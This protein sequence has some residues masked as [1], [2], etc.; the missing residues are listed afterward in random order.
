MLFG[1]GDP[2]LQTGDWF[3][4]QSTIHSNLVSAPV[5]RVGSLQIWMSRAEM[6]ETLASIRK[7]LESQQG[8]QVKRMRGWWPAPALLLLGLVGAWFI[9]RQLRAHLGP[10][11]ERRPD[12]QGDYTRPLAW[13]ATMSSAICSSRSSACGRN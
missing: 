10:G 9:A 2:L 3:V 8:M 12:R 1:G 11:Q 6:Q 4:F 13:C 7:Q 5:Q